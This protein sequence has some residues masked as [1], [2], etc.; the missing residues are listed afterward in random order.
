MNEL[1]AMQITRA[2]EARLAECER[3]EAALLTSK[4]SRQ[5]SAQGDEGDGLR[6]INASDEQKAPA[7]GRSGSR[8]YRDRPGNQA[9]AKTGGRRRK[10]RDAGRRESVAELMA[11]ICDD[12]ENRKKRQKLVEALRERGLNE[13]KVAAMYSGSPRSLAEIRKQVPLGW[14]RRSCCSMC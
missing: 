11:L 13:S 1:R 9:A 8:W 6:E 12:P 3:N 10:R 2:A 5:E 14:L 7:A 4:P